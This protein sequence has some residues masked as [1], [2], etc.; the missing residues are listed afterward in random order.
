MML[1]RLAI[2][3]AVVGLALIVLGL[4]KARQRRSMRRSASADLRH[5]T[6]GAPTLVYFWSPDCGP[7]KTVQRPAIDRV[8]SRDGNGNGIEL[9]EINVLESRRIASEW[10]ILSLPTTVVL[11]QTGEPRFINQGVTSAET[12][13]RQIERVADSADTST[14]TPSQVAATAS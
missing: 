8:V 4:V 13:S 5:G 3:A 2:L 10:K 14:G 11:D 12:L 7:C 9:V 1:V 6:T